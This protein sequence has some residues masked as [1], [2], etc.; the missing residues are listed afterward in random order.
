MRGLPPQV[1]LWTR[2]LQSM[3]SVIPSS[4]QNL[5]KSV[6]DAA[7]IDGASNLQTFFHITIPSLKDTIVFLT[8]YSIIG[9]MKFFDI[10]YITTKGGPGYSTVILS[11][12]IFKLAFRQ[13]K[14]GHSSSVAVMLL[15][16]VMALSVLM[17]RRRRH[18]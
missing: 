10:V 9:A 3:K 1:P 7:K 12:Y 8:I 17:L 13:Q 4:L 18:G 16:L 11:T 2:S 15:I 14:Q 5:D 6:Y